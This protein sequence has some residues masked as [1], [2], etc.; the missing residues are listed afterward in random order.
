MEIQITRSPPRWLT[1]HDATKTRWAAACL[2]HG[3]A[4]TPRARG[5]FPVVTSPHN[6]FVRTVRC[7][8]GYRCKSHIAHCYAPLRRAPGR[9]RRGFELPQKKVQR[10]PINIDER[11]L[12]KPGGLRLPVASAERY[13]RHQSRIL[14]RCSQPL[15]GPTLA[16]RW[17]SISSS[18][19]VAAWKLKL[20]KKRSVSSQ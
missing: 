3:Q 9:F 8:V 1:R 13:A 14:D 7:R 2:S 16:S 5:T 4:A 19:T 20:N 15:P 6:Q 11:R 17:H 12:Y 18:I 10:W